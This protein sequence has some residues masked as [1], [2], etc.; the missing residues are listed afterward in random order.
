MN[1]TATAEQVAAVQTS[2]HQKRQDTRPSRLWPQLIAAWTSRLD[3]R[4]EQDL[5]WLDHGGVIED[6]RRA[7]HD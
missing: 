6:F 3:R 2:A 1:V 4:I 5:R 7:S